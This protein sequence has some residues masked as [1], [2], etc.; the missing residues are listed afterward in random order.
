[1]TTEGEINQMISH[2]VEQAQLKMRAKDGDPDAM[3]E[4][5]NRLQFGAGLERIKWHCLA[6]HAG[7]ANAGYQFGRYHHDGYEIDKDEVQAHVWYSLSL[8][9]KDSRKV[10]KQRER[11]KAEMSFDEVAEAERLMAE[12]KP[13]PVE[14]YR[15]TII[16]ETSASAALSGSPSGALR[17]ELI[18]ATSSSSVETRLLGS[19]EV[20]ATR[21][22]GKEEGHPS[23]GMWTG[24]AVIM[25]QWCVGGAKRFDLTLIVE[26]GQVRGGDPDGIYVANGQVSKNGRLEKASLNNYLLMEGSLARGILRLHNRDCGAH[27]ALK[28]TDTQ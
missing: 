15:G 18:P 3:Y 1:V 20:M 2:E 8:E 24:K 26:N 22:A 28:K 17:E 10:A 14:C 6:A 4:Y 5:A 9:A 7:H 16:G 27:Y 12:W 23:D 19:T 11:L 25:D 21:E 13:N